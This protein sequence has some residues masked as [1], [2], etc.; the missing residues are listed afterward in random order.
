MSIVNHPSAY[1]AAD[2]A[3]EI[4]GFAME[5]EELKQLHP[6]QLKIIYGEKWF[7]LFVP[8][9]LGGLQCSLPE[10]LRQEE[11]IAWCD[12]SVG[13]T[14]T[15]CAGAGWFAGFLHPCL[16]EK[17]FD[18]NKVCIAGSGKASAVAKKTD[19]GYR[20]T[21]CWDY[22]TGSRHATAF[23][24]N[25]LVEQNGTLIKNADGSNQ[26]MSFLFLKD[27]VTV[28]ENWKR[29]G[30]I[31]T[32]SNSFEVQD[33]FVNDDRSFIID[34]DHAIL[35][36]AIYQY[37]FLQFAETTLAVNSSGMAMRFLD[38][39][40]AIFAQKS[41]RILQS[42]T[43]ESII[44]MDYARQQ[45]Y[46]IADCSWQF[47]TQQAA[48]DK[49]LLCE[50]SRVS[51][52]LALTSLKVVDELYPLCGMQAANPDTEINRVWRNLHTASQHAIFNT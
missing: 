52:E 2:Q 13:W 31:A 12:G 6:A 4:R 14:V 8:E 26:V 34:S 10:A 21:G 9:K 33:V 48:A 37:P 24:A 47:F 45:F 46:N 3:A 43:A 51:R 1:I 28:L 17:I 38:L 5:A 40:T 36:D 32:G 16:G 41:A 35:K 18:G 15:L 19:G 23:S 50:L 20:I 39:C 11:A 44:A 25:C 29:I 49:A 42:A 27:E 30:M 22:A 7:Q